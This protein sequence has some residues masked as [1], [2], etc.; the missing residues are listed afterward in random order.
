MVQKYKDKI[1]YL[2]IYYSRKLTPLELNYNIYDKEL[3]AIVT[4]LKEWRAFLQKTAEPFVVKMDYKNLIEFLITKELNC[5]QVKWVKMLVEYYFE[6]KYVK[7][8]DNAR[9]DVFSRKAEL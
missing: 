6:I 3:L 2:V 5:R 1:Q 7:G 8:T 4:V 9:A